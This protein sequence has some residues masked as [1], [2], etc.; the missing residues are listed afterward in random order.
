MTLIYLC[1]L[2]PC[3]Y[4]PLTYEQVAL[5]PSASREA[6]YRTRQSSK[7]RGLAVTWT[8]GPSYAIASMSGHERVREE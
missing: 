3:P 4:D 6:C 2:P 5:H 1:T 7:H 8:L